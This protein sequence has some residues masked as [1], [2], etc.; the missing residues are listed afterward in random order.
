MIFS[1]LNAN[2]I[3]IRLSVG[4]VCVDVVFALTFLSVISLFDESQT[5]ITVEPTE[6]GSEILKNVVTKVVVFCFY[7]K[8]KTDGAEILVLHCDVIASC[9][10]L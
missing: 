4:C 10:Y 5:V 8:C 1:L 9:A 7:G 6:N 2:E 3:I